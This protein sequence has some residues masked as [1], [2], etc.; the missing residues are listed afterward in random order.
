MIVIIGKKTY[1]MSRTE[2]KGLLQI[3]SE[4]MPFG[5]YAVEKDGKAEMQNQKPGSMTKLKEQ[6]RSFKAA[7]YKV[8]ANKG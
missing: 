3:A 2:F 4:Q 7:G 1:S 5:I 8:Y 6:I